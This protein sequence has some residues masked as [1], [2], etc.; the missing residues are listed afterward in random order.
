VQTLQQA[1]RVVLAIGDGVNDA[2]LLASADV[3]IAVGVGAP[4]AIAGADAILTALSLAPL[5]NILKLADRTQSIITMNL[6]WALIYNVGM[7][8]V[9]MLGWINPWIAG[10]GMSLSSLLVTLNAWRLRKA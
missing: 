1:G 9:A 4:L 6:T 10:V 5:S 7:I 8:P 3:S 2:P